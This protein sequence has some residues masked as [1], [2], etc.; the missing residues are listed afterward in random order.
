[1]GRIKRDHSGYR[2]SGLWTKFQHPKINDVEPGGKSKKNTNKWCRGK[3]G[4]EHKWHRYQRYHWNWELDRYVSPYVHIKCVECGKEKYAKTA[5]SADF[6][7]HLEVQNISEGYEP[8]QVRVNGKYLPIDYLQYQKGKY[9][10]K[11][12]GVWHS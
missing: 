2:T 5:K 10:C 11:S 12:C 4:V 7:L 1:M 8:I 3:V 6:P 9:W